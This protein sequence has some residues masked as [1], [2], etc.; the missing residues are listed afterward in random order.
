MSKIEEE[1]PQIP[2]FRRKTTDAIQ[3]PPTF[4]EYKSYGDMPF[5]FMRKVTAKKYG[6]SSKGIYLHWHDFNHRFDKDFKNKKVWAW[7]AL[8]FNRGLE[9]H[10]NLTS[11]YGSRFIWSPNALNHYPPKIEK[12]YRFEHT[13]ITSDQKRHLLVKS[14]IMEE[15]IT[16]AQLEGA[17]TTR[18]V[19]KELLSSGREP[20]DD[21]ETMILSNWNLMQYALDNLDRNL[22]IELIQEFNHIATEKVSENEHIPGVVRDKIINVVK[23]DGEVTHTAPVPSEIHRLLE[24]LCVYANTEHTNIEYIHPVIKAIVIHFMIGYIHPFLDGNGRTARALFYWY[25]IKYGYENLQYISISALLKKKVNHYGRAYIRTETDQFDLTYF[26]QFNLEIIVSA[27]GDFS[28]YIQNKIDENRR[29]VERLSESPLYGHFQRQHI[30]II[31]KALKNPGREFSVKEVEQDNNVS[32][33]AAR[34]Y[35]DKLYKLGLLLKYK[36][37]GNKY[38]YFAPAKLQQTLFPRK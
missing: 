30:D 36:S 13:G 26:I 28:S 21:S 18:A 20:A 16:S 8:H 12:L 3:H 14:L 34:G 19:A 6:F 9:Q 2:K 27:L 1:S 22:D 38:T 23:S 10:D 17:A 35:L 4:E 32:S 33:T 15:A 29:I 31:S 7:W 24:G 11:E 5:D 25:A 37:K